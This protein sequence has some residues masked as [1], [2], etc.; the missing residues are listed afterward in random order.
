MYF[1]PAGLVEHVYLN[2]VAERGSAVHQDHV[3]VLNK[4]VVANGIISN[5]ILNVFDHHVIAYKAVVE[6][7]LIQAGLLFQS[8]GKVE[9]LLE[10]TQLNGT[11]EPGVFYARGVEPLFHGDLLPIGT[12]APVL[13]H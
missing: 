6:D 11:R 7:S 5:V 8:P 4:A 2:P 3:H 10:Y 13:F 1:S 9:L 12:T